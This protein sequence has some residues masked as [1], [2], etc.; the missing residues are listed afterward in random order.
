MTE[1][2]LTEIQR[3]IIRVSS[4]KFA[5]NGFQKTTLSDIAKSAKI[6]KGTLFYH[7]PSKEELFFVV[8]G[9]SIDSA[10]EDEFD[11]YEKHGY[12]FFQDRKNLYDDLK[13]YYDL[14]MAKPK[15]V[16]K[17][18]LEG[19]IES[20]HNPKLQQM[21]SKKDNE[22]VQIMTEM[23]KFARIQIGILE[24][25]DDDDLLELAQGLAAFFRGMFLYRVMG[26]NAD[27]TKNVW[28]KT[29]YS[30]YTSKK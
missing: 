1:K 20:E 8:L 14:R 18:W 23:L 29:V 9:Q 16:E 13:K 6:S 3:K 11:F 28:V 26:K 21:L 4:K 22:I 24:G 5:K 12:K 2:P 10:F 17:L 15:L 27:E 7:Y 19:V 25:F 30:I